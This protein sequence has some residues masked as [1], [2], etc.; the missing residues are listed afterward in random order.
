MIQV[1]THEAK[2]HLSELLSKVESGEQVVITRY[3]KPVARLVSTG[4]EGERPVRDVIEDIRSLRKGKT[5]GDMS[6]RT[7]IEEGRE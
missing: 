1:G 4:K 5:L 7:M 3:D 2:T 6:L